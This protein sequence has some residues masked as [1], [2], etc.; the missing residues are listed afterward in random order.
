MLAQGTAA[1]GLL[2]AEKIRQLSIHEEQVTY[3]N[4]NCCKEHINLPRKR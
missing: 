1:L 4:Y 2:Q 3:R